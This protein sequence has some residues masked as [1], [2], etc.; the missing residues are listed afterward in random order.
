[1]ILAGWVGWLDWTGVFA[2]KILSGWGSFCFPKDT[3]DTNNKRRDIYKSFACLKD[4]EAFQ[5][6]VI[7]FGMLPC[8]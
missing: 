2:C 8:L 3:K 7:L 1:M 6:T 4:Q 5:M